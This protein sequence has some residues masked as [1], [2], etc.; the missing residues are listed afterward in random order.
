MASPAF[1]P[2]DDL[3]DDVRARVKSELSPGERLLWAG[4]HEQ[5]REP[6]GCGV[7]G[8]AVVAITGWIVLIFCLTAPLYVRGGPNDVYFGYGLIALIVAVLFSAGVWAS[9]E[10]SRKER[11]E[12][13]RNMFALTDRRAIIW[14]GVHA[15][16]TE[17]HSYGPENVLR[18]YRVEY[19]DGTGDLNF[20]LRHGRESYRDHSPTFTRI[21]DVRRVEEIAKQ[22][23]VV[24]LPPLTS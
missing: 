10:R 6:M 19:P 21:R 13:S 5:V 16:G 1:S 2:I 18:V 23:L 7:F 15:E 3:S 22:I 17:V 8:S 14:R 4:V 24:D 12:R 11:R 9:L 20:T